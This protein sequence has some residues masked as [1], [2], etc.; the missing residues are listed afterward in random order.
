MQFVMRHD[1]IVELLA[2]SLGDALRPP[3][4]VME[5]MQESLFGLL[6]QTLTIGF[7]AAL[8]IVLDVCKV[9]IIRQTKH[10]SSSAFLEAVGCSDVTRTPVLEFAFCIQFRPA[11]T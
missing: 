8:G 7:P 10:L 4:L 2:F 6:S 5:R 1:N 3:C 9:R 11:H